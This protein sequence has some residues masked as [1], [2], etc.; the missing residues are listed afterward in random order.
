MRMMGRTWWIAACVVFASVAA[1][2]EEMKFPCV[3]DVWV[4]AVPVGD[5]GEKEHDTNMGKTDVMKLKT[6]Q[7]MG[8]VDFDLT[9]LRGRTVSGGWLH[10][11]IVHDPAE[12]ERLNL[13]LKRKHFLKTIGVSTVS[14]DWVEGS[15][16]GRYKVDRRG[17]GATFREASYSKRPWAWAGSDLTDVTFSNGNTVIKLTVNISAM[18][19]E[20]I[21]TITTCGH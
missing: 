17:F 4:S 5:E 10:F 6:I 20:A 3:R 11:H 13:P 16:S 18:T 1:G 12:V 21:T 8:I 15:S 19:M 14:G 2:A 7:E 9:K